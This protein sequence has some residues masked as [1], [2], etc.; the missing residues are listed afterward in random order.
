MSEASPSCFPPVS[1][2]RCLETP[3][4]LMAGEDKVSPFTVVHLVCATNILLFRCSIIFATLICLM[5]ADFQVFHLS[6]TLVKQQNTNMFVCYVCG[7]LESRQHNQ[8]SNV[9]SAK[10]NNSLAVYKDRTLLF[11]CLTLL[12]RSV[13]I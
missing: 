2:Q 12:A 5:I 11:L 7:V 9:Q 3:C 4:L 10:Q 6:D 1:L 13:W 8:I